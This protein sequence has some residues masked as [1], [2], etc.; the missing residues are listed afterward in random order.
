M[1]NKS[2]I[3]KKAWADYR[4]Y[5]TVWS[6]LQNAVVTYRGQRYTNK[7]AP[8]GYF[9]EFAW[10][11]AKKEARRAEEHAARVANKTVFAGRETYEEGWNSA[12]FCLWERYGKRRIYINGKRKWSGSFINLDTMEIVTRN[13]DCRKLAVSFLETHIIKVG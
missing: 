3:M 9:L 12:E 2:E 4:Y 13:E 8:F 10:F 1:Y 11:C 5:R 6:P 7:S